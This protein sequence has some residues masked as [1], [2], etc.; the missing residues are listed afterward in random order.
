MR[1]LSLFSGIGGL[2]LAA[3]AAGIDPIAM[4]EI[5]PF[6]VE[7]LKKRFLGVP[8]LPDVRKVNGHDYKGAVDVVFGGFPCQDLSQAG[9]RA[10]LIDDE[11]NITRSGLWYEMLRIISES[12]PRY[13]VAENVRGAVNAALDQV[14]EGL[15][16]ED[17]K[18]WPVLIPASAVGA[19]HQRE[20]LFIL[21][22]RGD[23]A[24]MCTER[25]SGGVR[26]SVPVNNWATPTARCFK[27]AGS[28]EYYEKHKSNLDWQVKYPVASGGLQ[29]PTQ[30]EEQ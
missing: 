24:D 11:G 28:P 12:R 5:E 19:P 14:K 13:V 17:Y 29:T 1:G 8:I 7:V 15:E 26:P 10:G 4:C 25:I 30:T 16:G 9:K 2:D 18:V 3:M 23:I 21:G 27:G 6:P 22:I 20:R